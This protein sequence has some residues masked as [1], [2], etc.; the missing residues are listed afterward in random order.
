MQS[1]VTGRKW[2]RVQAGVP[3]RLEEGRRSRRGHF[4]GWSLFILAGEWGGEKTLN[5]ARGWG[6]EEGKYKNHIRL[7][8]N[9]AGKLR[10]G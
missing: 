2:R 8:R 10:V 5:E 3:R 9:H 4:C 7:L 6:R 1:R